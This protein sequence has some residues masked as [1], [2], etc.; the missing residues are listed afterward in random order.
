MM[1]MTK[2]QRFENSRTATL[3]ALLITDENDSVPELS[4]VF[5]VEESVLRNSGTFIKKI[6]PIEIGNGSRHL[7]RD[8]C[9]SS[10]NQFHFNGGI[11]PNTLN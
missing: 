11:V 9:C 3:N 8:L 6:F 10:S 2:F 7:L 1:T 5:P 4:F